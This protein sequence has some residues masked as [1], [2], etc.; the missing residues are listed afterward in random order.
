MERFFRDLSQDVVREGSFASVAE[1]AA[2]IMGYLAERNL[3]SK[4]YVWR[5]QGAAI[6]AKLERARAKFPQLALTQ[7]T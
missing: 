7:T 2:D 4:R 3:A 6:L 1:L 5:A